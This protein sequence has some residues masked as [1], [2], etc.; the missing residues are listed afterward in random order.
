MVLLIDRGGIMSGGNLSGGNSINSDLINDNNS[1]EIQ[2]QQSLNP[3]DQSAEKTFKTFKT[4]DVAPGFGQ[5][6]RIPLR[7]IA[8]PMRALGSAVSAVGG[9]VV[10]GASAVLSSLAATAYKA[11]ICVLSRL[12][13]SKTPQEGVLSDSDE[14]VSE[15]ALDSKVVD[16]VEAP[17]SV[18]SEE[19]KNILLKLNK[20]DDFVSFATSVQNDKKKGIDTP[21]QLGEDRMTSEEGAYDV[22]AE[23]VLAL[24]AYAK[25]NRG[26]QIDTLKNTI[27]SRIVGKLYTS[28]KEDET[29][30]VIN[31]SSNSPTE[32]SSLPIDIRGKEIQKIFKEECAKV[33]SKEQS[34]ELKKY[35]A[36]ARGKVLDRCIIQ[37]HNIQVGGTESNIQEKMTVV[38]TKLGQEYL[39][40]AIGKER[41]KEYLSSD[42]DTG[43]VKVSA[44]KEGS[45]GVTTN[46]ERHEILERGQTVCSLVHS[47]IPSTHG[48]GALFKELIQ[49]TDEKS[50]AEVK[51]RTQLATAQALPKVL[52]AVKSIM[53]DSEKRDRAIKTKTFLYSE[54]SL[55]SSFDSKEESMALEAQQAFE[56]ITKNL[57][58][59]FGGQD[60]VTVSEEGE[61]TVT[62]KTLE[63]WTDI[64]Q[65]THFSVKAPLFLQGVN[66]KQS[67]GF[68]MP[69]KDDLQGEVNVKALNELNEYYDLLKKDKLATKDMETAM[70][71]LHNHFN[72]NN[73]R[74][75]KDVDG[76]L[77]FQDTV[78]ALCGEVGVSCKSGKDRTARFYGMA[79][80]RQ[81]KNKS[82][83]KMNI[84]EELTMANA[85]RDK[86]SIGYYNTGANTGNERGYA[87]M[88]GVGLPVELA[89]PMNLCDPNASA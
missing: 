18:I 11:T 86:N 59:K 67:Q 39:K 16:M 54:I 76:L 34:K 17:K 64:D 43:A 7:L 58:I 60:S 29:T 62:L 63:G 80:A 73:T 27:Y 20:W 4:K 46:L 1:T 33:L 50:K 51:L 84:K 36:E 38:D 78:K 12:G 56:N 85:L 26:F 53:Q 13:I 23:Y 22:L 15:E 72:A 6:A 49:K 19:T 71:K 68:F 87:F 70:E 52:E 31:L 65:N 3:A 79:L 57:K 40:C 42:D 66:A 14:S 21:V 44:D 81:Y 5:F 48:R 2:Q 89:P 24:D 28:K 45:L 25:R 75:N 88:Y 35:V 9:A 10:S 74:S 8:R 55:V 47:G 61:I 69:W 41:A 77:I 32:S 83:R 82:E 37:T 30:R